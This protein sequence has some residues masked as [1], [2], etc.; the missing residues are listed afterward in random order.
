METFLARGLIVIINAILF[1]DCFYINVFILN[2]NLFILNVAILNMNL[3]I[4]NL[5]IEIFII[6]FI[7][8]VSLKFYYKEKS[9]L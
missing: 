3:F 4:F 7:D 2:L 1:I 8:C 5:K 6:I 9:L